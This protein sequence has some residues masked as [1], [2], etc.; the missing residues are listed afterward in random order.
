[1]TRAAVKQTYKN[2]GTNDLVNDQAPDPAL[3]QVAEKY[4]VGI[5]AAVMDT[6]K[7]DANGKHIKHDPVALQYMPDTRELVETPDER[8]DPIG[9]IP[10]SPV[11]GIV[12]RHKDRVLFMPT[13]T[14]AVYCRYCFRKEKLGAGEYALKKADIEQAL[15]YIENTKDIWEVILTGGDPLVLS[16]KRL[17]YILD[18]LEAIEHVAVIRIH[19]RVP[20]AAPDKI[21][22]EMCAA[23]KTRKALYMAVHVNHAQEISSAAEDALFKLH[24]SGCVLLSQ[25]VLLKKINDNA[26]TLEALF[27]KL[28]S[29]RVK[30]YYLHH[31][32]KTLGTSHFRTTIKEGQ[33]ITQELRKNASGLCQPTYILDIPGGHGKIPVARTYIRQNGQCS[34]EKSWNV[35][36]HQDQWHHYEDHQGNEDKN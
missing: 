21:T 5:T 4:N 28:V 8:F 15:D 9:D 18:R 23:L 32:D 3:K 10:H 35:L 34:N 25:T 2:R 22:D 16:A 6:I 7:T 20:V 36:D 29:I 17:K 19:S 27:R 12:H 33:H 24:Q 13:S 1:M 11:K 30:P 31:A 14:C 26:D